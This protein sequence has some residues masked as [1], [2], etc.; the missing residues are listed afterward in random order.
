MHLLASNYKAKMND[1]F[2]IKIWFA[3]KSASGFAAKFKV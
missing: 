2:R 1:I 3:A